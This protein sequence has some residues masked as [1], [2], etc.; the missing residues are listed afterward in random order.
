MKRNT[1]PNDRLLVLVLVKALNAP[2]QKLGSGGLYSLRIAFK[3]N[4]E[5]GCYEFLPAPESSCDCPAGMY[6]CG[7]RGGLVLPP[8]VS[9]I[10]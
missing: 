7:H 6:F 2:L 5:D 9:Q 3:L 10:N 8:I 4:D 1:R